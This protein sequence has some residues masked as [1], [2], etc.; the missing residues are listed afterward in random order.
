MPRLMSQLAQ[1]RSWRKRRRERRGARYLGHGWGEGRV[2]Y[3]RKNPATA[4]HAR[5]R[6]RQTPLSPRRSRPGLP[7]PFCLHQ[8]AAHQFEGD[9]Y[10]GDARFYADA[11][12]PDEKPEPYPPGGRLRPPT[13][14]R[15][16]TRSPPTTR[17]TG[18]S[19]RR[20]SASPFLTYTRY[21]K[22]SKSRSSSYRTTRRTT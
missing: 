3:L 13:G 4:F 12:G 1:T 2:S 9:Q 11:L 21:C 17:P 15:F 10:L 5:S 16:A 14:K 7:R 6:T 22:P 8:P 18:K 19:S 20:T